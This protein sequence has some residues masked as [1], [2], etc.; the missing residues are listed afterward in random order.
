MYDEASGLDFFYKGSGGILT[1]RVQSFS[2]AKRFIT[3]NVLISEYLGL[4]I[5]TNLY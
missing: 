3:I 4:A 1:T 5:H 2:K